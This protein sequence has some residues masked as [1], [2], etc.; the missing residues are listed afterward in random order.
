M[1]SVYIVM[2]LTRRMLPESRGQRVSSHTVSDEEMFTIQSCIILFQSSPVTIR[3]STVIALPAE[4]KFACLIEEKI[5]QNISNT[6]V[7]K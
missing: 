4:E 2:L 7:M 3:N 5:K 6:V 1:C